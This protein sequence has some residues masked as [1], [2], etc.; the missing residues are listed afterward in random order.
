MLQ[1]E[2]WLNLQRKADTLWQRTWD[3][4]L[5]LA[6]T[7]LGHA[8]PV[9]ADAVA[10][11]ARTLVHGSNLFGTTI[12][13]EVGGPPRPPVGRDVATAQPSGHFTARGVWGVRVHDVR[14]SADAIAVAERMGA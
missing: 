1:H 3:R 11:Q 6:V 13:P 4:H 14:S 7:G 5:R 8:H 9:V 12:G 2:R 10:T